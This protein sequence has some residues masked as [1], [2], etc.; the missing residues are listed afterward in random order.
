[1]TEREMDRVADLITRALATPD[2]DTALGMVKTEVEKLCRMFP[3]Y[4][5]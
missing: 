5:D 2:D 1:M 3:L 4:A